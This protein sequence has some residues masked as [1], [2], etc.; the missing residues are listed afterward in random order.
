MIVIKLE[1]HSAIDGSVTQFGEAHICNDGTGTPEI[2]NYDLIIMK[3]NSRTLWKTGRVIG[4]KRKRY[5]VW[6]LLFYALGS[7]LQNGKEKVL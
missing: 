1:L 6:K 7:M 4:F 5:S 2:G 3:P